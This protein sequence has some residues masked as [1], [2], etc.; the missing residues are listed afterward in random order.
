MREI[1]PAIEVG[2]QIPVLLSVFLEQQYAA[3]P[4]APAMAVPEIL[5]SYD[6]LVDKW[7]REHNL[8]DKDMIHTFGKVRD[9]WIANDLASWLDINVFYGGISKG[10]SE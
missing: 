2:W 10:I 7:L 6:V 9:D 5:A 4:D 3:T 1:R 8:T